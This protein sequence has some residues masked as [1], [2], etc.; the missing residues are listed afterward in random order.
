[1]EGKIANTMTKNA[2]CGDVE[3]LIFTPKLDMEQGEGHDEQ[4]VPPTLGA[5][6]CFNF[7]ALLQMITITIALSPCALQWVKPKKSRH[8]WRLGDHLEA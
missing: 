1:M 5:F 2:K 7:G 4:L 8:N 3:N 6:V